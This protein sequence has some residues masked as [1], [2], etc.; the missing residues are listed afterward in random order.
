[1][2]SIELCN[3]K[4]EKVDVYVSAYINDG[5]LTLSG[6]DLG[7]S[8]NEFWGDIDYEYYYTLSVKNTEKIHES[9]KKD[10]GEEMELLELVKIYFS[11]VDGCKNFREYCEKNHIK[12]DFYSI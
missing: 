11:G 2:S 10:S 7:S 3:Y 8:V 12:Y 6:Q 1:M 9:L 4:S 5:E